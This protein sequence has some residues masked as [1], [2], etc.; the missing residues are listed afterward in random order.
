MLE[1]R[2]RKVSGA[3]GAAEALGMNES[4]LRYKMK[5]LGIVRPK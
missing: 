2:N 3:G 5:K 1:Q 4:T